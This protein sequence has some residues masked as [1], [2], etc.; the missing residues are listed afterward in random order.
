MPIKPAKNII[1]PKSI[2]T[3]QHHAALVNS[4]VEAEGVPWVCYRNIFM[5]TTITGDESW[6]PIIVRQEYLNPQ[7]SDPPTRRSYDILSGRHGSTI[8]LL[9]AD[10]TTHSKD[11]LLLADDIR[12][13]DRIR[14]ATPFIRCHLN[15]IDVGNF[16]SQMLID[17]IRNSLIQGNYVILAYCYSIFSMNNTVNPEDVA[18]ESQA[19]RG[20]GFG[21][22]TID[23]IIKRWWEAWVPRE[24]D[25]LGPTPTSLQTTALAAAKSALR[26]APNA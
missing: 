25:R 14:A 8:N 2:E 1:N 9:D 4:G 16:T 15:V 7:R 6:A 13:R 18:M 26:G 22:L 24:H 21:A 10:G 23:S 17:Q 20:V 3:P 19:L 5:S 11:A 12:Q